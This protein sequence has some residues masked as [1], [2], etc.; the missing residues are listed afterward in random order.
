MKKILL[1]ICLLLLVGCVDNTFKNLGYSEEEETLIRTLKEENQELFKQGYNEKDLLIISNPNFREEMFAQY[2]KYI[3]GIDIDKAMAMI[4]TGEL[5]NTNYEMIR[6]IY[7][8]PCYVEKNEK[9]YFDYM[10]DFKDAR[11]LLEF[12]NTKKYI[13]DYEKVQETDTSKGYHMLLNKHYYLSDKY[14]PE[15]LVLM[16]AVYGMSGAYIRKDAYEAYKKMYDAALADG[17]VL[18][19]VSAYR[20]YM[21]QYYTYNNF[22]TKDPVEVVDTYSARP[23]F[24]EHQTGLALD[25]ITPGT[26]FNTFQYSEAA[27]WLEENCYKFGFIIRYPADKTDITRYKYEAW[28]V[29]FVDD[30]A[31]DVYKSGLTYDEYYAAYIDN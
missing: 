13:P 7:N 28:H 19:V 2:H 15:D 27:K 22:L 10:N 26:N 16:D 14:I 23:G 4:N 30:I 17:Y 1:I 29:R 25:V 5:N 24:S 20:S 9:L 31:E 3:D 12:V 6:G 18:K 8:D 21:T 11:T